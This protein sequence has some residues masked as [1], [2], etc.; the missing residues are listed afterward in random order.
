MHYHELSS[1]PPWTCQRV[2]WHTPGQSQ[3]E[4]FLASPIKCPE[5]I[6]YSDLPHEN[7]T[8]GKNHYSFIIF[9]AIYFLLEFANLKENSNSRNNF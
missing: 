7:A 4:L 8:K 1:M 6:T 9:L 3:L 5:N 2:E